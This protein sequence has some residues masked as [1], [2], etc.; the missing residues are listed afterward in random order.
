MMST[1]WTSF[2]EGVPSLQEPSW[3]LRGLNLNDVHRVDNV[4]KTRFD[5]RGALIDRS[6]ARLY[7]SRAPRELTPARPSPSIGTMFL[8]MQLRLD[9]SEGREPRRSSRYPPAMQFAVE[10]LELT[11]LELGE[12]LREELRKRPLLEE[13]PRDDAEPVPGPRADFAVDLRDQG[14][15]VSLDRSEVPNVRLGTDLV[16]VP[17]DAA[18]RQAFEWVRPQIKET[19]FLLE[20]LARRERTLLAVARAAVQ[21]QRQRLERGPA[22]LVPLTRREI[23]DEV[24]HSDSLVSRAVANKLIRTPREVVPFAD[25]FGDA[26]GRTK[27]AVLDERAT[28]LKELRQIVAGE[29]PRA[30]HS[31]AAIVDLMRKRGV[32]IARRTIAKYRGELGIATSNQRRKWR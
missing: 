30:P 26:S 25:L 10:I 3:T 20:V 17:R 15:V 24:G 16:R 14:P 21:H 11:Q 28:L 8:G 7:L 18:T 27:P 29:D 22:W 31:D 2:C 5:P 4:Q 19:K 32:D 23:A 9:Q 1:R 12:R 13:V 6:V